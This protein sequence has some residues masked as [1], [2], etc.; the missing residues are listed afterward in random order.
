MRSTWAG[1]PESRER[2]A[3][4]SEADRD[5]YSNSNAGHQTAGEAKGCSTKDAEIQ[6]RLLL[7]Q[8]D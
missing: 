7:L 5:S 3:N 8:G 1:P 6:D 2:L 4:H